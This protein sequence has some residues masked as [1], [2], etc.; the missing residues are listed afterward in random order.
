MLRAF[1][2]LI[3][4][5]VPAAAQDVRVPQSPGEISLSFAPLVKE[6]APAST[7]MPAASSNS[8][9]PLPTTRSLVISFASSN[10]GPGCR[11]RW[12]PV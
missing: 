2:C 1:V 4:L 9:A 8:A 5:A 12:G 6:A 10:S 3:M 7:F 11:I